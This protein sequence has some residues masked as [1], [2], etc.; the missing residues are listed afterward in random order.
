MSMSKKYVLLPAL[1]LLLGT[2]GCYTSRRVAGDDLE[3][4]ITN[5]ALWVTVPVDILMSPYQIPKWLS[6]DRDDWQPFDTQQM[7]KDYSGE[8]SKTPF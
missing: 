8:I 5:P 7:R 6:D 4:G 2:T 1:V 3:G